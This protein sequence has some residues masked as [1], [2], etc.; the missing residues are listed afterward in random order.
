MGKLDAKVGVIPNELEK[1]MA[2]TI[3]KNF[4]FIN[5]MQ[6]MNSSLDALVKNLSEIDFKYLS[7]EYV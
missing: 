1:Y 4:V 5:S 3:N 6:F 2:F 7:Q